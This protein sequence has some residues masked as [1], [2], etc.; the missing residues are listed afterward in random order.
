MGNL[1]AVFTTLIKS[2][3]SGIK[4]TGVNLIP[5]ILDS[6]KYWIQIE[7]SGV[8]AAGFFPCQQYPVAE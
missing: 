3:I 7:G 2:S 6:R 4:L 8:S 1:I 5:E